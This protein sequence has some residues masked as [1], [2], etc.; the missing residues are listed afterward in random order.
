MN[1]NSATMGEQHIG[2][3]PKGQTENDTKFLGELND[4]LWKRFS[5]TLPEMLDDLYLQNSIS[6][7]ELSVERIVKELSKINSVHSVIAPL[8]KKYKK[9]N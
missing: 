2:F 5:Q 8:L 4:V 1:T 7:P 3:V 6:T 9:E